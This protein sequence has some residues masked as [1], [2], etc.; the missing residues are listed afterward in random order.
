MFQKKLLA[1]C[2]LSLGLI[3]GGNAMAAEQ[4]TEQTQRVVL[5]GASIGKGW[6]FP[7]I[8]QRLAL[9][10]YRFD[11][12]GANQFDKGELIQNLIKSPEKPDVVL[13]KECSTYF[14][15]DPEQ[16]KRK[17]TEWVEQ[18]R[19]SGVQ[20]ILVTTAPVGKPTGYVAQAKIMIKRLLGKP[21]WLDS[22]TAFNDWMRE[23]GRTAGIRVFDIEALLRQDAD[24]RWLRPDYDSGDT[25]HLTEAAYRELD[26]GFARFLGDGEKAPSNP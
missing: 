7:L 1:F 23:Y 4:T 20:P 14:P 24:E 12:V 21:T 18:L 25:V 10:G 17:V 19:A 15:G 2:V 13:I 6:Q 16:Y 8:G 3:H 11:Y 22:I 26:R 9:A 5:V